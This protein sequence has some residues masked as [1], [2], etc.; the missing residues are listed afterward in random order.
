VAQLVGEPGPSLLD[1]PDDGS[2]VY[3]VAEGVLSMGLLD[4][5]SILSIG[6][7]AVWDASC[8]YLPF[9]GFSSRWVAGVYVAAFVDGL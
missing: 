8:W 1:H 4:G 2:Y 7:R 9:R 3:F 5:R 6:F